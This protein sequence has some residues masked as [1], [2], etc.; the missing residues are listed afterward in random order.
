MKDLEEFVWISHHLWKCLIEPVNHQL[1]GKR[2]IIIPD[3]KLGYLPFE[4]LLSTNETPAEFNY[5]RLP[6][7]IKEFPISYTY[8]ASLR[9]NTYF[10]NHKE[11]DRSLIAFAPGLLPSFVASS[12]TPTGT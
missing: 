9:F 5:G 11:F 3:G 4:L 10:N 6:F 2:L 7:L 1:E 12:N 8:S